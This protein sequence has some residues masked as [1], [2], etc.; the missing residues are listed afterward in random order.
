MIKTNYS[1]EIILIAAVSEN[2]VLGR[3][4]KLIWHISEDL[5]RFKKLTNG[6]AIIMGR[7]TWESLPKKY[8]PDRDNLIISK[9]IECSLDGN[10]SKNVENKD[11]Y[12]FNDIISAHIHCK[13][14][15][16]ETVWIIGGSSIYKYFIDQPY[17]DEIIVTRIDS[18]YE[19]DTFFPDIPKKFKKFTEC[20]FK[21]KDLKSEKKNILT[22]EHYSKS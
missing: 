1:K 9:S 13:I 19:C 16:Y 5:K 2:N 8:L 11:L 22:I 12:F 20:S 3:D 10:N 15:C 14:H 21:D 6:H 18:E 4:N 17:I 7:K